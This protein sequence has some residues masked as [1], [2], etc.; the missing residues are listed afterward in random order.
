MEGNDFIGAVFHVSLQPPIK[1]G[2]GPNFWFSA[3]PETATVT[4]EF[5]SMFSHVDHLNW[6]LSPILFLAVEV[7]DLFEE[8]FRVQLERPLYLICF[9]DGVDVQ[10]NTDAFEAQVKFSFTV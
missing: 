3:T 5:S 1:L 9:T 7:T 8:T 2:T 10:G 6:G 4:K